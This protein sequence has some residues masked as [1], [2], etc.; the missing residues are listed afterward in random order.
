C[1]GFHDF[2]GEALD[3]NAVL[4]D[5]RL[6]RAWIVG[7]KVGSHGVILGLAA[8]ADD[9]LQVLGQIQELLLV[10][11]ELGRQARLNEAREVVVLADLIEAEGQV[12]VGTDELGRIKRT[13][14]KRLENF[15][16][17]EVGYRS[18]KLLPHLTTEAGGTEA[19]ALD[20]VEAIDLI[21]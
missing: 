17:R 19:N 5:Q 12:V 9:R 3:L 2:F 1:S 18:A 15:T 6:E 4:F 13:R 14:L 11:D 20:V 7:G 16:S 21:A 10:D 8:V